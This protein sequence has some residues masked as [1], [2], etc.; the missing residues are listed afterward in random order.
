MDADGPEDATNPEGVA[1][2]VEAGP[3]DVAELLA[4][5][6]ALAQQVEQLS[7]QKVSK[8]RTRKIIAVVLV[9][10]FGITFLASGVGIW[11]HRNTL[12]SDVW[13]ERVVP[14]GEDP[15]VQAALAAYTTDQLMKAVKPQDLFKEALPER[16]QILAVPLSAAVEQFVAEKVDEF[17]TSDAFVRLWTVAATRAHDAA[18]KT[19]RGDAPAVTADGD[20]ITLNLIPLIDE[21]LAEILK[22]APG[23]VGSDAKLPKITVDDVPDQAR[24]R[25]GDAL[26]VDLGPNFGQITVYDQGKLS[27]A[28]QVVKVFDK[29]VV[30]ST[31]L[32]VLSFVGALAV[33]V[34]RRRTLLQLAGVA[35]AVC[36][37]VRRAVFMLQ[38][39][40]TH[41]VKVAVNRPAAT[42]VVST[43]ANPLTHGAEVALWVIGII[44]FI[45]IVTGPYGWMV[46]IR[47]TIA[48]AFGSATT[49]VSGRA[50]DDQTLLWVLHNLDALRIAGAV[51]G[52]L[53]LWFVNL[54]WLTFFLILLVVAGWEVL[55]AQLATRGA[56]L[57][58]GGGP[59][60]E[61]PDPD[62]D[63]PV[64]PPT[65]DAV[66]G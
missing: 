21:V 5:R 6:D 9:V 30:L 49:A 16:A 57:E 62:A 3:P 19:L 13:S 40:V 59:G 58:D 23:L 41:V 10:V 14:L 12:N 2:P 1:P 50:Q 64:A 34:R 63:G 61:G 66:A 4:E 29:V 38:D 39:D 20:K 36:I 37:L 55:V 47:S 24:Q 17:Y 52:V 15:D 7:H 56:A 44:A 46:S 42:V 31:I 22:A 65:P 51:V 28:Q 11:L 27:T 45:A 32:V 26:G 60:D 54:T 18:I 25:L 8:H 53:L 48:R 33:S 35:A 43:F